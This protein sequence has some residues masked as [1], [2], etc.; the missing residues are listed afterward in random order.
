MREPAP[1]P[2]DATKLSRRTLFRALGVLATGAGAVAVARLLDETENGKEAKVWLGRAR[3]Y[4]DE[5]QDV[6]AAGLRELGVTPE[7][8]RGKRVLLKPN[9]VETALGHQHINT[10]P[11]HVL[12]VARAFR[13][14]G[15]EPFLAEGQG[16]RRDSW[17]VLQESGM[18][19]ILE[20]GELDF[21]DLN[22][23]RI[24]TVP[25][26]GGVSPMESLVLPRTLLEADWVVS[27]PKI[28]T[29]HW[30][31][32]TCAMKNFFGVAPGLAYGWPKNPLHYAGIPQ[33]IVDLNAT[34]Q[35]DFAIADG[36]VGMEGDGPIM[37]TPKELGC[38]VMSRNLPALDATVARLMKLDPLGTVYLPLASGWLGPILPENIDVVGA[39]LEELAQPFEV[40]DEP[41][42]R[43]LRG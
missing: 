40:L 25:N 19:E 24:Q 23:D 38:V 43:A 3:A 39:P 27:L 6:I 35:P 20:E 1:A 10:H 18:A 36:I 5:L 4:D 37:G 30:A 16:H 14:L 31:G 15:A 2:N 26:A 12:A 33:S 7:E 41:H 11:R 32:I 8:L 22:H 9:L 34:I 29:H 17:L 28:K 42:L 13:T 21:V